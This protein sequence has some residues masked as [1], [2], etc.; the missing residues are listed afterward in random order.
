[1]THELGDRIAASVPRLVTERLVLRGRRVTDFEA[2]AELWAQPEQVRYITGEPLSRQEAWSRFLRNAGHWAVAG[3]G[4][5]VVADRET[6]RFLGDVGFLN[7]RR[8]ALLHPLTAHLAALPE[9][10]WGIHPSVH[11]TGRATEAME[12]VL[13]WADRHGPTETICT[14]G[15][16]NLPSL[17]LARRLGYAPVA[18]IPLGAGFAQ[19]FTR[20]RGS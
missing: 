2:F 7:L 8:E 10:G 3:V 12:A 15:S 1:M 11:G 5:W 9:A 20:S 17:R 18:E 19:V 16:E 14:V 4:Y 13:G 6:D